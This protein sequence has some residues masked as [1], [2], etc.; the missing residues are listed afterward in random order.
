M[1]AVRGGAGNLPPPRL[2]PETLIV[3]GIVITRA[4]VDPADEMAAGFTASAIPR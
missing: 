1:P 2:R 3:A 4:V